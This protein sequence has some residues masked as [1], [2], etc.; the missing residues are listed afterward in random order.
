MLGGK[1]RDRIRCY[2]DTPDSDDPK[3]FGERMKKRM[4]LGF[5]WLKMDIGINNHLRGKTGHDVRSGAGGAGQGTH[6]DRRRDHGE[7]RRYYGGLH[8]AGA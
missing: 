8:H 3:V 2:C 6:A 4:D 7:R 5:T 1:Y